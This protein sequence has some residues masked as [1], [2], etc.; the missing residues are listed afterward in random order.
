MNNDLISREALK[1]A[2]EK[3]YPL[4]TN[5]IGIIINKPI[6][7]IIDNAPT[8]EFPESITIKCD[9]EED[10]QKLLSALRNARVTRV[11]EEERPTG[12]WESVGFEGMRYA[13][14]KCSNCHKTTKIYMDSSN[15]FCCIS[16]IRKKAIACLYCGADMR[17]EENED[18]HNENNRL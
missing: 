14:C 18:L 6:Y 15:D 13:W 2:F 16:D 8:V 9:T 4:Y 10:K 1:K 5:E 3:A 7:D 11:V 12:H 17:C